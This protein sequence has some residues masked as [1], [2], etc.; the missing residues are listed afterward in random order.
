MN[1]PPETPQQS[2]SIHHSQ[3]PTR[4]ILV[5]D[6]TQAS[7]KMLSLLLK[8][9]GQEV[10]ICIDGPSALTKVLEFQ[11]S[12]IF[13]DIAMP[14]MSG[15]EVAMK[16]KSDPHTASIVLVAMTGFG[17]ASDRQR[18]F[19]CGFDHHMIKPANLDSLKQVIRGN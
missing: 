18:A 9:L 4:R 8:S 12:L 10:E 2:P 7:G 3:L 17:Q 16:L 15:Y 13:L 5:V 19:E 1:L 11:P 6:D 14:G